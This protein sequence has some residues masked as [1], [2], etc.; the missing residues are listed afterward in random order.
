VSPA[1]KNLETTPL[2]KSP[3]PKNLRKQVKNQPNKKKPTSDSKKGRTRYEVSEEHLETA[4]IGAKKGL[5]EREIAK[6]IG[7]SYSTLR[8][9][10][11]QFRV[12][13]KKGRSESDDLNCEKVESSML[14]KCL[15]YEVTEKSTDR[16]VSETGKVFISKK[17]TVRHYQPSD[18]MIMF[19][20]V[21][22]NPKRWQSIN[23]QPE[24]GIDSKGMIQQWFE[25][26]D[27][28]NSDTN[29]K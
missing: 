4:Y 16:R 29:N 28:L 10:L 11:E 2:K 22:R 20:L 25:S 5:N 18:T 17:E 23:K 27:K 9:N 21:N 6:A 1:K 3:K 8:R 13:I 14:K 7:I 15:G 26:M 12:P 24:G 19:Y